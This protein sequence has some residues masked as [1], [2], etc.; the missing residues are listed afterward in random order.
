V[1]NTAGI[2]ETLNG[3]GAGIGAVVGGLGGL[4][5]G[6]GALAIPGIGPVLAAGPLA[7]ALGALAGAG[8]GAAAG[9]LIGA[10][11]DM[12]IPEDQAELYSEGVRRGAT[13]VIVRASDERAE[14][15]VRIMN[16]F[17]PIDIN[18]RSE[19]WRLGQEGMADRSVQPSATGVDRPR[20]GET[21]ESLN[22]VRVGSA[23]WM[24]A[25]YA[26]ARR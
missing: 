17:N 10:M 18:R 3:H 11:V 5:V 13:L 8:I 16:Q 15:A 23:K 2:D 22:M 1:A 21:F 4:L 26:L 12:G 24:R 7:A 6:L 9:G 19:E 20:E 14:D 25:A